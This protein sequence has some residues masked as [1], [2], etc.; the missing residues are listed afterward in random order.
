MTGRI[1]AKMTAD[2]EARIVGLLREGLLPRL[3][4]ERTG[5][6]YDQ[7]ARVIRKRGGLN[8]IKSDEA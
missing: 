7:V 4:V 5:Y 6:S 3:V 1:A 2:G 8:A